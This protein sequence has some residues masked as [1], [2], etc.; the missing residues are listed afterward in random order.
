[1]SDRIKTVRENGSGKQEESINRSLQAMLN[2][3]ERTYVD[4]AGVRWVRHMTV[5][6]DSA[7]INLV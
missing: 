1:M 7:W 2:G 6:K 4:E 3:N 5:Y